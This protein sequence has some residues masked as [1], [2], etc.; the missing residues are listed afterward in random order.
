[1][2][3]PQPLL[4]AE[5][6]QDLQ[7]SLRSDDEQLTA[8]RILGRWN[9]VASDLLPLLLA[10]A[11]DELI[12]SNTRTLSFILAA[13]VEYDGIRRSYSFHDDHLH[14]CQSSYWYC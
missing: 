2:I 9:I 8:Q 10:N 14:A 6:I 1:M 5:C 12:V 4:D 13:W 11:A 3:H 7:R